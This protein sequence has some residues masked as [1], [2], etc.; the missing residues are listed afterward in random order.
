MAVI[1]IEGKELQITMCSF[2]EGMELQDS[3]AAALAEQKISLDM[4]KPTKGKAQ[5]DIDPGAIIQPILKV[6]GDKRI[7][8]ALFA[9]AK[10]AI[11]DNQKVDKEFFEDA[12][13]RKLY[14]P[15]MMEVLKI[16]IGPF[17]DSLIGQFGGLRG[18]IG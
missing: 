13:N 18:L 14:Y 16:N 17:I 9:C 1:K 2:D 6:I 15:I 3:I 10:R 5:P 11:Y 8:D 12:S 7:R 4:P